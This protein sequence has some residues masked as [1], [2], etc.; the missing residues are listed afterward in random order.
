MADLTLFSA[1]K[2]AVVRKA[3]PLREVDHGR[4][5]TT[6]F[7]G[8]PDGFQT[9]T[10]VGG[11]KF[12][13]NWVVW[14]CKT[15]IAGDIGKLRIKL[16]EWDGRIWKEVTNNSP[17]LQV[18]RKPNTYQTRQQFIEN[19]LFSLFGGNTYVLKERDGRGIVTRMYVLDPERVTPL[20]SPTGLVFYR[21]RED[22]L[23]K[24]PMGDVV[25][26]ASE[27]IHDRQNCLY[28]PL[29]GL[30]TAFA[31]GLAAT[32]GL[33]IQTNSE[34][35]FRN[36][37]RP[38]GIL[39]SPGFINDIQAA[40]YKKRW[41]ENFSGANIGKVAVL[42]N[43]L[44]YQPLATDAKD[45]QMVEQ[46]KMSAEMICSVFH[47]PA[48]KV[49]V[50]QIPVYQ[51]AQI[52]NQIYFSDC[53]QRPIEAIEA[54]LDEGLGLDS[55]PGRTLGTM[56]DVDG[57]LRMDTV[58]Q[59]EVASKGV[60]AAIYSPDEARAK[61]DLGTVPGGAT[62]YLQQQNYSL[63]ALAKRDSSADPFAKAP[64]QQPPSVDPTKA[65]ADAICRMGELMVEHRSAVG[66]DG[67]DT[68]AIL[69]SIN[70]LVET[71]ERTRAKG[72]SI[73]DVQSAMQSGLTDFRGEIERLRGMV[74]AQGA[75]DPRLDDAIAL[76]R[77]IAAEVR[78]LKTAAE[79]EP[80]A[81]ELTAA[82]IAKFAAHEPA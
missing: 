69:A 58:S 68:G 67:G 59:M 31:A 52:L 71:L 73:D 36:M 39:T 32:Q 27:I 2:R 9:D 53:L 24:V 29:V 46:L 44:K 63:A 20:V 23:A 48:Y 55:V 47:V 21:L 40:E 4:G 19:W 42:G 66:S 60:G 28:H 18:L 80:T 14:S 10:D 35:F 15:L 56:F 70:A 45:S 54:L 6:I 64:A 37:S 8:N 7:S 25:V 41:T 65:I 78:E 61:F 50:G 77:G 49:G 51:S 79:D 16:V 3:A 34:Q 33:K 13:T 11:S 82:L 26:P 74:E 75:D 38:S 12:D 30:S 76:M 62:P 22:L 43:D 1:L 57:L 5:W 81:A 17:Y 72:L